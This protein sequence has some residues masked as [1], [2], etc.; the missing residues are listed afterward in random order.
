MARWFER[1]FG[2]DIVVGR[3]EEAHRTL[4]AK[5]G[6]PTGQ[7]M[8]MTT[9]G[10]G[11]ANAYINVNSDDG[12]SASCL[13][14]MGFKPLSLAEPENELG[15]DMRA[16]LLA[17]V[18]AQRL[19][20]PL[21]THVQS[22]STSSPEDVQEIIELLKS[23]NV[24]HI[25]VLKDVFVGLSEVDGRLE[26]DP[27]VDG[28][29]Y[30]KFAPSVQTHYAGFPLPPTLA[31][32]P[33]VAHLEPGSLV[34]PLAKTQV[35]A[36]VQAVMD[37]LRAIVDWPEEA[38]TEAT[39]GDGYRSIA[40]KPKNQ[41]SA[42]WE[43]VEPTKADSRAGR[44]LER[45]GDGPWSIRLGVFGLDTKLADL[46]A[47]G[48]RWREIEASATG[49]RRVEI[50]RWDLHGIQFELEDMPVVYRGVGQGRTA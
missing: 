21:L 35:V 46:D 47:R 7:P 11:F 15:R 43:F 28:G 34:R 3:P 27:R 45:Y 41:L 31:A 14:L 49:A 10:S 36:S 30:L 18:S 13:Q 12:L 38:D 17:Y 20:R 9:F 19:D 24:P 23:R 1:F 39:V 4:E 48:T 42:V 6:I 33:E 25:A 50:S 37:R 32:T 40:V 5:L 44:V 26:Y 16:M 29:T 22:V 2:P 8:R